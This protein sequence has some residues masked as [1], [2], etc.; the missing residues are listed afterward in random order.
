[1]I[2]LLD[3]NTCIQYLNSRNSSVVKKLKT[4]SPSDI[5]LCDIVKSELYYGAYKSQRKKENLSVLNEFFAA[6]ISLP[7]DESAAKKAGEIRA[8]LAA[9][10][11]PIGAYDLQIAAIALASRFAIALVNNLILVTHNIREF[12]RIEGLSFEDWEQK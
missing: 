4:L 9:L 2:Y 8:N 10:G 5:A 7:F 6:F 3:T 1:M 11:T 12:S